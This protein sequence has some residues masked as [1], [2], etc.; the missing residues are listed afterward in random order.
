MYSLFCGL[1]AYYRYYII[2]G[3]LTILLFAAL[4]LSAGRVRK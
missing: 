3:S 4:A 2:A 1:D